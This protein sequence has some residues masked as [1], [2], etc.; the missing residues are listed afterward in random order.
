MKCTCNANDSTY[1]TLC[2]FSSNFNQFGVLFIGYEN[3]FSIFH[4]HVR[5]KIAR[6]FSKANPLAFSS[7]T[8]AKHAECNKGLTRVKSLR[9]LKNNDMKMSH[10]KSFLLPVPMCLC[11][12]YVTPSFYCVGRLD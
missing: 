3:N 7:Q 10:D 11:L 6:S 5:K 12:N 8:Q 4:N 9:T 2:F 1:I